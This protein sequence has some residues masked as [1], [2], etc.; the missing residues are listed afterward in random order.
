MRSSRIT[1]STGEQTALACLE[2]IRW[3]LAHAPEIPGA[4]MPTVERCYY[5]A[6]THQGAFVQPGCIIPTA[7]ALR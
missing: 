6:V 5:G 2:R 4:D 3:M 1:E 7:G